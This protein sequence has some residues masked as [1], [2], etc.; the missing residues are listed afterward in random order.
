[1][2]KNCPRFD[3]V[4]FETY[5]LPFRRIPRYYSDER[6]KKLDSDVPKDILYKKIP[7]ALIEHYTPLLK[8][9]N[10]EYK[11]LDEIQA[12]RER[13]AAAQSPFPPGLLYSGSRKIRSTKR[14]PRR[15]SSATKRRPRRKSTA[16]KRRRRTS[17]K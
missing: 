10:E 8:K 16:I 5:F 4:E 17:R 15:K 6:I 11:A 7:E 3:W 12:Q 9:H 13:D 14:H 1:M 2:T